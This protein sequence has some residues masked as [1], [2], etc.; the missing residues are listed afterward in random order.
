MAT[1]A[2][3]LTWTKV[4]NSTPANSNTLSTD[5]RIPR[6]E[7][8][9]GDRTHVRAPSVV[10][11]GDMYKMWYAGSDGSNWRIYYAYSL[12]GYTWIKEDNTI[13]ANSDYESTNGRVP[14]GG[15]GRGDRTHVQYSTVVSSGDD[16]V[17]YYGGSDG[18]NWRIYRADIKNDYPIK[19]TMPEGSSLP[20]GGGI[21]YEF[22]ANNYGTGGEWEPWVGCDGV[23]GEDFCSISN[24]VTQ[25]F[26]P[27]S[28]A[29]SQVLK[30]SSAGNI[31]GLY[32]SVNR[33]DSG[34]LE[35]E[36]VNG[37]YV[38]NNPPVVEIPCPS[39]TSL[40]F[41][42]PM[43]EE[44]SA[45]DDIYDEDC[46][47]KVILP[48]IGSDITEMGCE[49]DEYTGKDINNP[50]KVRIA[51]SD[52]DGNEDI[53]GVM[54]ILNRDGT[55][56]GN[57]LPKEGDYTY[58]DVGILGVMLVRDGN[59]PNWDKEPLIYG[60]TYDNRWALLDDGKLLNSE[61]NEIL[62]V[63]DIE[64]VKYGD[65][66]T[67]EF[68]LNF[69]SNSNLNPE[70]LY[71]FDISILDRSMVGNLIDHTSVKSYFKWGIDL[72][73]PRIE[74]L[75][76]KV[77]DAQELFLNWE[78]YGTG[79]Y[80]TDIVLNGY[81]EV[82]LDSY[83]ITLL[84]PPGYENK[85][86]LGDISGVTGSLKEEYLLNSWHYPDLNSGANP[87]D[88][89]VDFE[90]TRIN[91][92]LNAFGSIIMYV[93]AYDKACN[94]ASKPHNIDLRSWIATKGGIMYSQGGFGPAAKLLEEEKEER[95]I[96]ALGLAEGRGNI[97]LGDRL[98]TGTG[99]ISSSRRDTI[100]NIVYP[101][102]KGVVAEG[103]YDTNDRKSFWYDYLIQKLLI[104]KEL[105]DLAIFEH[106]LLDD[107]E[108]GLN[109]AEKCLG[110]EN[111]IIS[112]S[113][114]IVVPSGFECQ[115]NTLILS[116][117]NII[118]EPNVNSSEGGIKGCIFLAKGDI[119]I[120]QGDYQSLGS[121]TVRYDYLDAFLIAERQIVIKEGDLDKAVRDGLLIFG[122]AL[123]FGRD[124]ADT[125]AI[126]LNRN[127]RLFNY[128]NP[129]LVVSWA[130][131]YTELAEIFFG[132]ESP[133]Y[134]Q[135][136]GFKAH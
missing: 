110:N 44:S 31:M 97:V 72:E 90:N 112:S 132:T 117:G 51:G 50:L 70:G 13:P 120:G 12:D 114:N 79:S 71:N 35:G 34:T 63:I 45:C 58:S 36:V 76:Q 106:E 107:E 119:E 54:L 52:S 96:Q 46:A 56:F 128:D 134:K 53:E 65:L 20:T 126:V 102:L 89:Y 125:S 85:I 131:K 77:I 93:T 7:S 21:Q 39:D 59:D 129:T 98:L 66:V 94:Y 118:L 15:S 40:R 82:G 38:I 48:E 78:A 61:D 108:I 101:E 37:Y 11:D 104:Q 99:L 14:R 28:L 111:C 105:I 26:V 88:P 17:I 27:T 60:L 100:R 55:D 135:E 49:S 29:I 80:I 103:V 43:C 130:V 84:S 24:F 10:K 123:A 87:E 95:L 127:L 116:G 25:N 33:C 22:R 122:S 3:G 23:A 121:D 86:E 109:T 133:L 83:D 41:D 16:L 1:S 91:I 18:S 67:F 68:K 30:D 124:L 81:R 19:V 73:D 32:H 47:N 62:R 74:N 6:G 113:D 42:D 2:D 5:G 115:N 69:N 8:G 4:N 9:T 75:G 57:A 136:V 64:E 92:G